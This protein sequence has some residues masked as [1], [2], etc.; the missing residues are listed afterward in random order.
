MTISHN[1]TATDNVPWICFSAMGRLERS[2]SHR[3]K[4]RAI[5]VKCELC[6]LEALCSSSSCMNLCFV[7][8]MVWENEQ[9]TFVWWPLPLCTFYVQSSS[10]GTLGYHTLTSPHFLLLLLSWRGLIPM[11]RQVMCLSG[12]I[13]NSTFFSKATNALSL[14]KSWYLLK[15]KVWLHHRLR[16]Y[17]QHIPSPTYLNSITFPF[18]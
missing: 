13:W 2:W 8:A 3:V 14:L 12:W 10:N 9:D 16:K 17:R 5:C 1:K 15:R 11:R 7:I 18:N 4:C 6:T